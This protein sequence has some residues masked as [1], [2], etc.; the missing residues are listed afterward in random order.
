MKATVSLLLS[1]LLFAG[2]IY[3]AAGINACSAD[4]QEHCAGIQPGGGAIEA[5]LKKHE[6]SLSAA[7]MQYRQEVKGKLIAFAGAC[8][9][10]IENSCAHVK[11]GEGRILAC[12]KQHESTLSDECKL[13]LKPVGK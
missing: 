2:P 1:A 7:C 12:L 6:Q 13:Q 10:D 9:A 4:V 5:C 3:A 8:A 11:P